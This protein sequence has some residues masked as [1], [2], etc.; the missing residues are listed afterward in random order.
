MSNRAPRMP[1][2]AIPPLDEKTL[3]AFVLKPAQFGTEVQC[4]ILRKKGVFGNVKFEL[5]FETGNIFAM[6]A[7]K[8]A[9]SNYHI[10]TSLN[11]PSN[12]DDPHY[13]GKVEK[14]TTANIFVIY[15]KGENYKNT[16][17]PVPPAAATSWED[18]EDEEKDPK[19]IVTMV[20]KSTS[21]VDPRSLEFDIDFDP[22]LGDDMTEAQKAQAA[23]L[24]QASMAAYAAPASA[25]DIE[26]LDPKSPFREEM[27]T[28]SMPNILPASIFTLFVT[29]VTKDGI[30]HQLRPVG[31]EGNILS[32]IHR[33]PQKLVHLISR[34]PMPNPK[35]GRLQMDFH[36]R[37]K[38][39]SIKNQQLIL[40][41]ESEKSQ[42]ESPT[43]LLFGKM[44]ENRFALDFTWPLCP[45]QAFAI[46]LVIFDTR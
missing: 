35:T 41:D 28:I 45:L 11:E 18:E 8:K 33:A 2:M 25:T 22:F 24:A 38:V 16:K 29:P 17:V 1:L 36:G 20:P 14:D 4:S 23:E 26:D 30:R 6:S 42:L 15:G 40:G 39:A 10:F 12:K 37:A 3:P 34:K 43:I 21:I 5:F 19:S 7:K 31:V 46:A 13:A 44:D 32:I 9:T 27:G